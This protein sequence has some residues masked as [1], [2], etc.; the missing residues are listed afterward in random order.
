MC[1]SLFLYES[2]FFLMMNRHSKDQGDV[3][4]KRM[5][6]CMH[7][8]SLNSQSKR[9]LLWSNHIGLVKFAKDYFEY[10]WN[11]AEIFETTKRFL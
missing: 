8:V 4:S 11:T 3:A 5:R 9:L 1:V 6:T 7:V 2:S 10:L